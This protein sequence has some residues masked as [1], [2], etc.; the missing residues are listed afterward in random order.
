MAGDLIAFG[1][2][3]TSRLRLGLYDGDTLLESVEGPGI[4]ALSVSPAE[5]LLGAVASWRERHG[6][7]RVVLAG[8]AGSRTGVVEAPY[9]ECPAGV[10]DWARQAATVTLDGLSVEVAPGVA[11]TAPSGAPDVMR[12]EETQVFGAMALNPGLAEGDHVFVLPGT[13]GKWCQVR[14]GRIA[15]FQTFLTGELFAL[16]STRS[17]LLLGADT[18]DNAE[19]EAAGFVHG[20]ERARAGHLLSALFE[21]RSAQLREGR[22]GAW[23]RGFLSGLTIG[24]EVIEGAAA[25]KAER[26]ILV[27]AS[28]LNDRYAI[29]LADRSVE[30]TA[31]SGEVCVLAG[32]KRFALTQRQV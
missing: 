25:F 32:L 27:G 3:G 21:A 10:D 5:T 9:A 17:S 18:A 30:K 1:D 28:A 8:M 24:T 22:T 4:G 23:A 15:R 6:L 26:V 11:G 29:A 14:D 16:L 12:G 19:H 2:W 31:L 7:S 13:H 20:L